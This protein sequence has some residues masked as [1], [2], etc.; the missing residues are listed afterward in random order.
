MQSVVRSAND[1]TGGGL[2]V[3]KNLDLTIMLLE[4]GMVRFW[5][6]I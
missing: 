2:S 3:M 4:S 6:N 1:M 5:L